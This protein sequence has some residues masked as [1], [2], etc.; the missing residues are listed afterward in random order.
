[1]ASGGSFEYGWLSENVLSASM[2]LPSGQR[3]EVRE[4]D[5]RSFVGSGGRAGIVVEARLRTRRSD[6]D[7]PFAVSFGEAHSL[8]R[9]VADVIGAGVPLW[10]WRS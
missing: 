1:M 4:E 6:T 7:V 5:Q 2:V 9:A 10:N 3:R 8:I